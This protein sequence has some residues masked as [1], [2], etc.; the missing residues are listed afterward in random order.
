M[1]GWA[2]YIELIQRGLKFLINAVIKL[3]LSPTKI[4]LK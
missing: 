1:E 2:V 4:F 3:I